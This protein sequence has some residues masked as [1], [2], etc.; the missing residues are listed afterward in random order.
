MGVLL[1]LAGLFR[2]GIIP[3]CS[4]IAVEN[5]ISSD[6][7]SNMSVEDDTQIAWVFVIVYM[8]GTLITILEMLRRMLWMQGDRIGLRSGTIVP[9]DQCNLQSPV[10]TKSISCK[11][12]ADQNGV[13]SH[14]P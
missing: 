5:I 1:D 8:A 11:D 4:F 10:K 12:E 13:K 9:A 14:S 7:I 2:S 3:F 6:E